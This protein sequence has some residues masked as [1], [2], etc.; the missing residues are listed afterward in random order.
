MAN[1][2]RHL[3]NIREVYGIPCVVAV[4]RFPTDT[5]AEVDAG[6]RAGR[7]PRACGPSP[8]PTSPTA[9]S[10]AEDLAKGVL[11][12]LDEPSPYTFSF[13]YD[14]DLSLTAEGRDDRHAGC[15]A[16]PR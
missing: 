5:D 12:V 11:E 10:G 2:R 3:D 8:R 15:T 16:P 13:T 6:R 4:N 9:G 1:L 7:R 14:D